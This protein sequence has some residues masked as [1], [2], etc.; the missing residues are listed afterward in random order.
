MDN[1]FSKYSFQRKYLCPCGEIW[2]EKAEIKWTSPKERDPSDETMERLKA[3]RSTCPK[4]K[5]VVPPRCRIP[6]EQTCSSAAE[7]WPP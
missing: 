2:T 4:C 1:Y 3:V 6:G 7:I 5:G